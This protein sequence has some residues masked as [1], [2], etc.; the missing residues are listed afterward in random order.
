MDE[1]VGGE[2]REPGVR[3]TKRFA[4]NKHVWQSMA[5]LTSITNF[6]AFLSILGQADGGE[7]AEGR[8]LPTQHTCWGPAPPLPFPRPPPRLPQVHAVLE[9][10]TAPARPTPPKRFVL[11]GILRDFRGISGDSLGSMRCSRRAFL[12]T[13]VYSCRPC[14]KTCCK[15]SQ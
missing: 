3:T 9:A 11:I 1:S 5:A 13:S 15:T 12:T 4:K 10:P 14:M 2:A 7:G 6:Q 8:A